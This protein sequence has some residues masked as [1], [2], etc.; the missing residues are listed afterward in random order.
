MVCLPSVSLSEDHKQESGK[1]EQLYIK[2]FKRQR[3]DQLD[4]IK[5]F[6]KITK[7]EKQYSFIKVMAEKV[8]STIQESRSSMED[9][10]YIPGVSDFP[11]DDRIRNALSNIL[12]NT[13]LFAE[14]TLRFP[15]ITSSVLSTNNTWGLI[16]QWGIGFS[17]Q[18]N[19]LLD[20]STIKLLHLVSQE[21]NYI[22]RDPNFVNPYRKKT[23]SNE[24]HV[25]KKAPS[26][27]KKAIKRGPKMSSHYEL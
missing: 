25:E 15:D 16:F 21:L 24:E 10:H 3:V 5:N 20:T 22:E 2:L 26:K 19:H 14:I 18:V 7:Y 8:F 11:L 12:E 17:Q 9:S 13:A 1:A 4:A 6:K 23:L 27:K